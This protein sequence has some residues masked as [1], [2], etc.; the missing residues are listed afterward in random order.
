MIVLRT[1]SKAYGLAGL[2][3]GY[4][5]SN[6]KNINKLI[7]I[8]PMYEVNS[9]GVLGANIL[10]KNEVIRTNYLKNVSDGKKILLNFFN[11]KNIKFINTSGNF[12]LFKLQ[13]KRKSIFKS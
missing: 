13:K 8:K 2:R 12:V 10:L 6:A 5:I 1:F 3:I 4:A 11:S 7:N 9:L